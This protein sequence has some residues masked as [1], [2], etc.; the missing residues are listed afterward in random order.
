MGRFVLVIID[1]FGIGE[2]A[3]T[4]LT[5]P[6]DIGANTA[7][8]ILES[9]PNLEIPHLIRLGLMN[10]I[11]K[12]LPNYPFSQ[13]AIVGTSQLAHHGADSFLGH[14]EI[15]GII[16]EIPMREP[17]QCV[18]NAVESTLQE[19]GYQT[20]RFGPVDDPSILLVNG[21]ATVGDNLETDLGMVY[22]VTGLLD[23]IS[24]Q[25]LLAI[26]QC[27]RSVVKVGRVITFG[28]RN[29]SREDLLNAYEIK[30]NYAGVNAPKS[31]VYREGYQVLHLGYGIDHRSQIQYQL[32]QAHIPVAL[33]GKVSDI[34]Y[35]ENGYQFT[36]ADT[37]LL[38]RETIDQ[39]KQTSHGLICLN[40]QETDLAG[41]AQDVALYGALLEKCD[42]YLGS[43]IELLHGDDIL[44]V[45]AD[46]GND[47][48]IGH[49]NHTRERVPLLVYK[50][51]LSHQLLGERTTMAD[52]ARTIAEY[53]QVNPPLHGES[54]LSKILS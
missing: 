15:M 8:H 30:G 2:M 11:G 31:G 44:L 34:I 29:V 3:D 1:S 6:N 48:T 33:I 13:D 25:D 28:G 5:R 22:N 53:F 37:D 45:M 36:S 42:C 47:P 20:E 39:I 38:F 23:Q 14:Q 12:E 27:V 26:G 46:H 4:H 50:E 7:L 10:S 17:F 19:S 40:I 9:L 51:G 32:E 18:I 54:F 43:I 24:F 41:H 52:V 49:S 35:S 21:V 16:P